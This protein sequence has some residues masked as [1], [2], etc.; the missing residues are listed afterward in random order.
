MYIVATFLRSQPER[1]AKIASDFELR[2][3]PNTLEN[4]KRGFSD[5]LQ[6]V[7]DADELHFLVQLP[8][9]ERFLIRK[10]CCLADMFVLGETFVG[11]VYAG[12]PQITGKTV[13]DIGA[14][15]GDTAVYF[16]QQ[17]ARVVAYEPSTE[18]F[19]LARRNLALNN[20]SAELH[21]VGV[22]N[23]DG[24]YELAITPH[25]ADALS[26]TIFPDAPELKG[27]LPRTQTARSSVAIV[28]FADELAR[29]DSVF[30]VKMD[31]EGCEFP[32]LLSLTDA[33][34]RKIEHIAMEYHANGRPLLNKLRSS[35]FKVRL[36]GAMY[37]FADRRA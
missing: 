18:L 30:L 14:C 15:L 12:Y 35:G 11:G 33:Q 31:C 20:V 29:F 1:M 7:S 16:A 6:D 10:S 4:L 17:G 9:G 19:D 26:S 23:Q 13:I 27:A 3:E 5:I 37:M 28:R 32:V 2:A 8:H 25:G 22:G 36:H 21:N 34:L 24:V